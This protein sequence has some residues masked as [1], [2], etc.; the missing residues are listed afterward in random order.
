MQRCS[1]PSAELQPEAHSNLAESDLDN[2]SDDDHIELQE[3]DVAAGDYASINASNEETHSLSDGL[4]AKVDGIF[5]LIDNTSTSAPVKPKYVTELGFP[6]TP[7]T[8]V[9][10]FVG[11]LFVRYFPQ[12]CHEL[13][14]CT[15]C[16][17]LLGR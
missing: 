13:C 12:S 10:L 5:A 17:P 16:L 6:S 4:N 8:L 2:P 1:T 7:A 11:S 15:P 3:L 9:S 14:L